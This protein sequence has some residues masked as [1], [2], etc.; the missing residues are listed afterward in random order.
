MHV[1]IDA[2]FASVEEALCPALRG[3]P[4]IVGG[5]PS[6]R[7]VVAC[8]NYEARKL[9]VR[10]AMPISKAYS[11]APD[12][13]FMKGSYGTYAKYSRRFMEILNDFSPVVR[14]VSLDEA[15]VDIDGCLHLWGGSPIAL[16]AAV[17]RAVSGE[18]GIS[19]SIGISSNRICAKVATDYSKKIARAEMDS[20]NETGPPDGLFVVALGGEKDFLAPL[21]ASSIP[22][23]G[24]RTAETLGSLG[25]STVG[26]LARMDVETLKKIFGVVGLYLHEAAN[27]R[28]R[29]EIG[30]GEHDA[31]SI[32]RS[33]TFAEDSDDEEFISS[34]FFYLSEKIAR[35]LR[36]NGEAAS[37]VTVRMRYSDGAPLLGYGK[38]NPVGDRR[39]VTYQKS[40]TLSEATNSEFEIASAGFSLFSSLWLK[41]TKVRLVGVGVTNIREERR[42]LD[43][44]P[45]SE[46]R[47]S[48]LLNGVDKI[49]RK[50]GYHS[51]YFGI[52]DHLGEKYGADDRGFNLHSPP[53]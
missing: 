43:L 26:D 33:T 39:F 49:R 36:E 30:D 11:L 37:T 9:G 38:G 16:A 5:L 3:K 13:V 52:V 41:G 12:A 21:P 23:I 32:S 34:V 47:Q 2:F 24:R 45:A 6:G 14:P 7:G 27:G 50:F 25:V 18:L 46:R 1:D 31:K 4:V 53:D 48:G 29:R 42:Q 10:T 20:R 8:P 51:I 35:E 17:K 19:V 22:G 40:Y 28:G 44:F 15:Y